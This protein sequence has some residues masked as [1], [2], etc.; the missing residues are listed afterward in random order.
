MLRSNSR[1]IGA[2]FAAACSAIKARFSVS[3]AKRH[4][5]RSAALA[6]L[7]GPLV[8]SHWYGSAIAKTPPLPQAIYVCSLKRRNFERRAT[9]CR[10]SDPHCKPTALGQVLLGK[11]SSGGGCG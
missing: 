1:L 11:P 6:S 5:L 3:S 2:C 4:R 8:L 7:Y 9:K 10:S